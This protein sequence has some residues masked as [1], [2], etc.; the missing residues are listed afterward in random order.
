MS[1]SGLQSQ[2]D[3]AKAYESLFVPALFGQWVTTV[4]D[5]AHVQAGQRALD[6]ACGTGVLAREVA[7]RIGESGYVAGL[8]PSPGMLAVAKERAPAVD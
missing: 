8:D 5:S 3:A 4:A 1:E 2:I 7:S 6:V